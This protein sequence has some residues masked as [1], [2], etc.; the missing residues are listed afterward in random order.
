MED[1]D[2]EESSDDDVSVFVEM[3]FFEGSDLSRD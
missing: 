1:E 3:L 2:E